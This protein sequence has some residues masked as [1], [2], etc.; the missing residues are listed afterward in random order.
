[1]NDDIMHAKNYNTR[2]CYTMNIQFAFCAVGH[3][4][5]TQVILINCIQEFIVLPSVLTT[6]DAYN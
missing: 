1:M 2:V 6:S 4:T 5:T 3:R